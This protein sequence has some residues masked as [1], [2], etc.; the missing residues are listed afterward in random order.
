MKRD[1]ENVKIVSPSFHLYKTGCR[2]QHDHDDDDNDDDHDVNDSF[3][4]S[5]AEDASNNN[6]ICAVE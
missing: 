3:V 1:V 6:T 5:L 4:L 2:K